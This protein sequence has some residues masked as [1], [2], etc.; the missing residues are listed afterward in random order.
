MKRIAIGL[1]FV[2]LFA[3]SYFVAR[4]DTIF[5]PL[6]TGGEE[7]VHMSAVSPYP[8]APQC[9]NHDPTAYHGLWNYDLGCHYDHSHN[10]NPHSAAVT[11]VFGDYTDYTGYEVSYAWQTFLGAAPGYPAPPG[12]PALLENQAKHN[13]YKFD[14]YD[15]S[16]ASY[17]CPKAYDKVEAVPKAWL[18]ERHSL[19]NKHDF[20]AR[21]HSV[22]A[23][24]R[25]C[26]P[27]TNEWAYLYTGGWQDFGQ[28]TSPYKTHI[29]PVP[30]NPDP[31]YAVNVAPYIA[32]A[33]KNH[34]DC[35]G[36]N[37][38]DIAWISVVQTPN[39][40]GHDLFRFGFRANDSQQKLDATNGFNQADPP[41][42][43]L[44]KDAQGNYVAAG[45]IYNHTATHTYQMTGDIGEN[46]DMLDGKN[47]DRVTYTGWTDR[48]GNI[49]Q[50]CT[51]NGL[52]CVPVKMVNLP[53]G[54]YH[55]NTA[56]FGVPSG[57]NPFVGLPDYDI[58]F[59]GQPSGW[60]GPEN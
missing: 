31:G 19:G 8:A 35:R 57:S 37:I 44:C 53:V 9:A 49:V 48:W 33:C 21:V 23:M 40:S 55:M 59:N 30:G 7:H 13:G 29:I 50:G 16:A 52:D 10:F 46:L 5:I 45:C 41:F 25:F 1:L 36:T 20:M 12:D 60:I 39:V 51:S 22:W 32:H 34:D 4:A 42:V 14:F 27:G 47:D 38:S 54:R 3:A 58:Y 6:I 17:G 56:Q 18:I 15:F 43:Y 24:V 28:R 2:A 11:A 26:I